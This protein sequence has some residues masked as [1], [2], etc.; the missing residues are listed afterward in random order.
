MKSRNTQSAVTACLLTAALCLTAC[1]GTGSTAGGDDPTRVPTGAGP[2][3]PAAADSAP[4]TAPDAAPDASVASVDD[5]GWSSIAGRIGADGQ[6]DLETA[7]EAF[8]RAVTPLPGAAPAG[9]EPLA[10]DSATG[11]VRWLSGHVD[12]LTSDQRAVL[13]S[14]LSAD[15]VAPVGLRQVTPKAQGCFGEV[16][17]EAD[18]VGTEAMRTA[19]N[20]VITE[21][22]A[23]LGPLTATTY[24]GFAGKGVGPSASVLSMPYSTDCTNVA[25][26]CSILVTEKGRTLQGV[27]LRSVLAREV[28]HCYQATAVSITDAHTLAPWLMEG[29]ATWASEEL[30]GGSGRAEIAGQ[31]RRY[32]STPERGLFARTYDAIGFF[33]HLQHTGIDVWSLFRPMIEAGGNDAAWNVSVGQEPDLFLDSWPSSLVREPV[34]GA[35]W[36]AYG[37]G[38]PPTSSSVASTTLVNEGRIDLVADRA[39]NVIHDIDVEADIVTFLLQDNTHGRI[40]LDA[41]VEWTLNDAVGSG[42]CTLPS[43]CL[44]PDGG[45]PPG[46]VLGAFPGRHALIAFNGALREARIF[47][48]GTGLA[49]ACAAAPQTELDPCLVGSWISADFTVPSPADVNIDFTGGGGVVVTVADDGSATYDF[50]SMKPLEFVEAQTGTTI[51]QVST[52]TA[53]STISTD[54]YRLE[55]ADADFSGVTGRTWAEAFGETVYDGPSGVGPASYVMQVGSGFSCDEHFLTYTLPFEIGEFDG[56]VIVDFDR[57]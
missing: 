30:V 13:A 10:V 9:S 24:V 55:V 36:E 35:V 49:E 16:P 32:L 40:G 37:P 3:N 44:C 47:V 18:D 46:L 14:A 22:A 41:G 19:L 12:Q 15:S 53:T 34:R 51:R 21:L 29:Y 31:W 48:V 57:A 17:L 5:A 28:V 23:R 42:F 52:G 6:V 26:S 38:I 56:V 50:S 2:L 43:G 11:T 45:Q 39:A 20:V 8:S 1:A 54:G 7:I 4:V 25:T 27:A 33:A